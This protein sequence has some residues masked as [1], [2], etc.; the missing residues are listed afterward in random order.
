M[1]PAILTFQQIK[2]RVEA[3]RREKRYAEA[4]IFGIHTA[5]KWTGERTRADGREIFQIE[6]CESPLQMRIALQ[7]D[8]GVSIRVLLTSLDEQDLG[9]DIRL[10]LA[11]RRLLAIES[12]DTIKS[13]FQARSIDPRVTQYSWIAD[14]L[15]EV[16]TTPGFTAPPAPGGFLDAETVWPIL[17]QHELG[18]STPRLDLL[19]LLKWVSEAENRQR[20]KAASEPFRQAATAWFVQQAG[21]IAEVV[22]ASSLTSPRPDALAIGLA[23]GVIF[24]P[25][26]AGRLDKAVGRMEERYFGGQ[27]L[28]ASTID[29]WAAAAR[30]VVDLQ[31]D[32][33]QRQAHLK[34]ADEILREVQADAYA[35]LSDASPLGFTQRLE[36]LGQLLSQA[37]QGAAAVSIESLTEARQAIERHDQ[38]KHERRR[39]DRVDMAIRLV[40][41]LATV[42]ASDEA[43]APSFP[44][45]AAYHLHAGGFLDWARLSLLPSEPVRGLSAAYASLYAA[46]TAIREQQAQRFAE[47]LRDWTASGSSGAD[48]VPVE[49]ILDEIVAPLAAQ[50]P[51]LVLVLDGMSAA[52]SR[53]LM[54]HIARQDWVVLCED[55]RDATRPGIATIPSITEIS[56]A[57]LLCGQLKQGG[58]TVERNGFAAH[59]GLL[60][61]S[62]RGAPPILF[63]KAA[64]QAVDEVGLATEVRHEI[65]SSQRRV[66]GVVINA[67]DDYLLKSEQ[68]EVSWSYDAIPVLPTLLEEAKAAGRV[69]VL[70][71]DHGHV[72][73]HQTQER[74]HDGGERWRPADGA[75]ATGELQ[76]AGHRVVTPNTHQLIAPWT[77]TVRYSGKKTGYHGGLSPQEMIIPI[78][79]LC[80]GEPF[81]SGWSEA[82]ID[83]PDWWDESFAAQGPIE[84]TVPLEPDVPT[85]EKFGPLFDFA[86]TQREAPAPD[87]SNRPSEEAETAWVVRLLASPI[88]QEQKA[89]AGRSVPDDA[90]IRTFLESLA[91]RGGKLTSTA[92]ARALNYPPFRLRRLLAVMQRVLNI[93]GYAVLTYDDA[94]D[95][96]D[97]NQ[98]LLCRQF[99]LRA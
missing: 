38:A 4:R 21:P 90:F 57:S 93:D 96:V 6:Q 55:G 53:E 59:A 39:L 37:V 41:W 17:L 7:D 64:L 10:R 1:T 70:L 12:W 50:A 36:R 83:I 19:A 72:L 25:E 82:P 51:V 61:H 88:L 31:L 65:A 99:E 60:A 84:L 87:V 91:R 69:V 68:I 26:T 23:A 34:R 42:E 27:T 40:R 98:E 33:T 13:L 58:Q 52:V 28:E 22:I 81:P 5:A 32:E 85:A 80:A 15:L 97:L 49:C 11:K 24:H 86:R 9:D 47:L 16:V 63:H 43:V 14:A 92:L 71:S 76:I 74:R 56:R 54:T 46:V 78:T 75:P 8:D 95:T 3:V 44:T 35:F 73:E 30:E 62:R 20:L 48:V 67:V 18:L 66:V 79:V 45:A 94:S 2:A 77:E 89:I 29:R